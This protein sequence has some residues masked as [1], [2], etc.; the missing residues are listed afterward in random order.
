MITCHLKGGLGNQMFQIAATEALAL[1]NNDKAGYDLYT[2]KTSLQGKPSTYYKDSLFKKLNKI[3]PYFDKFHF[4]YQE[5][6]FKYTEIP[7]Q[8]NLVL[9]G[10]FQSEKYFAD[11]KDHILNL[12]DLGQISEELSSPVTNLITALRFNNLTLTSLHVRRGD[13]LKFPGAHPTCPVEYYTEAMNMFQDNN[14]F[15]VI[16]DD[17]E[18]CKENIKG[19]NIMY[20]TNKNDIQDLLLMSLC[21]NNIIANSS[22][23][24]WGAWLNQ[25]P[26][27]KV[28]APGKWF[29]NDLNHDTK[30]IYCK[31]WIII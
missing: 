24:W 10:Y 11:C 21:D 5:L 3:N 4:S 22:F 18:W 27:K 28:V 23:S 25:T 14:I 29:G 19:T 16:S 7:Y 2:C 20:S 8:P 9:N 26:D 13:Y 6:E 1:R 31:D 15:I 17:I 30:D 12:F